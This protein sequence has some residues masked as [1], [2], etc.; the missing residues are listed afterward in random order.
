[1]VD[2]D[3]PTNNRWCKNQKPCLTNLFENTD[4]KGND[5][6]EHSDTLVP[7]ED[8]WFELHNITKEHTAK[9]GY[10]SLDKG[11]IEGV[12]DDELLYGLDHMG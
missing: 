11:E 4:D 12:G 8:T 5:K 9:K 10:D 2:R 3:S 7:T 1:V 6:R